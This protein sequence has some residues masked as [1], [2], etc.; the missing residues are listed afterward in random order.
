MAVIFCVHWIHSFI[1]NF[2]VRIQNISVLTKIALYVSSFSMQ[3]KW[4]R[5]KL[6]SITM[7]VLLRCCSKPN[8][9]LQTNEPHASSSSLTYTFIQLRF[10]IRIQFP[11][12]TAR[13]CYKVFSCIGVLQSTKS[14]EC[15]I[16]LHCEFCTNNS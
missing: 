8:Y 5:K 14:H 10:P 11:L 16:S 4:L 2:T 7:H 12:L 9:F 15:L 6:Y 1:E 3:Q 13:Y